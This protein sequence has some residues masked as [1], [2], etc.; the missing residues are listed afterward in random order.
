M[1]KLLCIVMIIMSSQHAYSTTNDSLFNEICFLVENNF[2]D[3]SFKGIDWP[4]LKQ[5]YK[6]RVTSTTTYSSFAAIVNEMLA[7]LNASHTNYYTSDDQSYY[8]L[9]DIFKEMPFLKPAICRIFPQCE[10]KFT[11]IGIITQK[12]GND[13]FVKAIL[14]S[15]PAGQAGILIG[16]KIISVDNVPFKPVSVF[17]GKAG[18]DVTIT[19]QRTADKSS[20]QKFIVKPQ[21][22]IP[23]Q[24]FENAIRKSARIIPY[25]GV[26]VGY[27]HIWSFAGENYYETLKE[28]V[29]TQLQS[30]KALV[31]DLR[32]GP[33]GAN[34][35]YLNFFNDRV[36]VIK[37]LQRDGQEWTFDPQWRKPVV[38][39]INED[40]RSGKEI[41]AYGFKKY[42]YGTIVGTRTEGAVLGARPHFLSDGSMLYLAAIRCLVDGENLEGKGVMPDI[43]VQQNLQYCSGKDA[44]MDKAVEIAAKE[45]K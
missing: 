38:L 24:M 16:D 45:I 23:N 32:F 8:Y 13:F 21:E 37:Q 6:K 7:G 41:F 26:D 17:K 39:L 14:D 33:G 4:A 30:A 19:I 9:A 40:T 31:F 15:S 11:D 34:P 3:S 10:V 35:D 12:I 22:Y 44:Q 29:S 2:Y 18:A 28:V 5:K 1:K 43:E 25:K 27:I 42:H 36:P 20:I